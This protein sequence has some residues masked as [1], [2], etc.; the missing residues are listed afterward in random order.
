MLLNQICSKH[1]EFYSNTISLIAFHSGL[2]HSY[3]E[4]TAII[5]A[6]GEEIR[7][8]LDNTI[9]FNECDGDDA[10]QDP[11]LNSMRVSMTNI[12][13]TFEPNESILRF[14]QASKVTTEDG[15]YYQANRYTE[16][17]M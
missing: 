11:R 9:E 15:K 13:L 3:T 10:E 7:Y 2:I 6:T 17:H 12:Y 1:H 16:C 8:T 14:R 4:R 5:Q